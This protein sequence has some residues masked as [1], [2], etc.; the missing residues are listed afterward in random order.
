MISN[1]I[2]SDDKLFFIAHKIGTQDA[3]EWRLVRVA[4][5]DSLKL[6]PSCLQDGRFY[7][8][9]YILH[10]ADIR[11]NAT[12]QRYWIHYHTYSE[13]HATPAQLSDAHRI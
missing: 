2:A 8:D 5:A 1:I 13:Y 10:P 12:N 7:V 6:H 4:L 9:F 3:S 11:Y